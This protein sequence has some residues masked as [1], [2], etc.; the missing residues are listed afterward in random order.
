MGIHRNDRCRG[1]YGGEGDAAHGTDCADLAVFEVGRH[2]RPP[3]RVCPVHLGPSL[4]LASGV[5]WPPVIR[6][7]G[8]L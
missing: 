7:V 2:G 4:L 5:L 8:R 1:P 3:L 6:L